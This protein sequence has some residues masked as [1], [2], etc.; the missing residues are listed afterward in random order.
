MNRPMVGLLLLITV[1]VL[2]FSMMQQETKVTASQVVKIVREFDLGERITIYESPNLLTTE[3]IEALEKYALVEFFQDDLPKQLIDLANKQITFQQI[4]PYV[5]DKLSDEER[6]AVRNYAGELPFEERF[7]EIYKLLNEEQKQVV[8]GQRDLLAEQNL[9]PQQ[10]GNLT[11][12]QIQSDQAQQV[13]EFTAVKTSELVASKTSLGLIESSAEGNV[14]IRGS[15][16]KI[17]GKIEMQKAT[18]YF[19]NVN[20]TCCEMNSFRA[21][22]AYETDAFGNFVIKFATTSKFPLGDWTVT[23]STIGDDNKII[24]HFYNFRLLAPPE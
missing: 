12:L 18:P 6:E 13:T 15:I 10:T 3:E 11:E 2:L 19:Y 7:P 22:S 23:I 17:A 5:F 20:I 4:F 1:S 16:V 8:K 14:Y 9:H 24:K 21:L